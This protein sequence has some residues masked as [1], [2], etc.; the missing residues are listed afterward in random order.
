MVIN[1]GAVVNLIRLGA[2]SIFWRN[3]IDLMLFLCNNK[4]ILVF[5]RAVLGKC[6]RFNNVAAY[7]S[8]TRAASVITIIHEIRD[9]C[10]R[11]GVDWGVDIS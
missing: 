6:C 11:S 4:N 1:C 9:V 10:V 2:Y 8:S 7:I 5:P 3:I